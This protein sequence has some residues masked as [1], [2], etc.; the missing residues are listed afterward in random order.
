[1]A[2]DKDTK[3]GVRRRYIE[4]QSLKQ[5]CEAEGVSYQS[6]RTWKQRAE[7]TGDNWDT[8]RAA[9]RMSQNGVNVLTEA[10]LEDFIFLYQ[11]TLDEIKAT[12]DIAPLVKVDAIAKLSDAYAKT[13]KAAAASA[14]EL[15]HLSIALDVTKALAE[16]IGQ[17]YPQHSAAFLEI[18]E[19]FGAQLSEIYG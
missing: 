2:H 11:S 6:G 4:G 18:L 10:V 12:P 15:A 19:P 14:P 3:A 16:F 13:I 8:A 9:N 17:H 7:M 5:A 1:M